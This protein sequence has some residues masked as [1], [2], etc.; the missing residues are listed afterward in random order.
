MFGI[1]D[2]AATASNHHIGFVR[3][4]KIITM[5]NG[6]S[7]GGTRRGNSI[8]G[9][10]QLVVQR[11]PGR[12]C[13]RHCLQYPIVVIVDHWMTRIHHA[14]NDSTP[15]SIECVKVYSTCGYCLFGADVANSCCSRH[16][17]GTTP[18]AVFLRIGIKIIWELPS[19]LS[20]TLGCIKK[21][22]PSNPAFSG[23]QTFPTW[24]QIEPEG[25]DH[26]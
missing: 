6:G 10:L 9:A 21:G 2:G 19:N 12:H 8:V 5:G 18:F 11:Y 26:V 14:Q 23:Y 16:L 20:F 24:L 22:N 17:S 15:F 7:T 25:G 4:D 13:M 3:F 1:H